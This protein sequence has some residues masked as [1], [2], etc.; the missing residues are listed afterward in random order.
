MTRSNIAKRLAR[1][2][3]KSAKTVEKIYICWCGD[4]EHSPDC[5]VSLADGDRLIITWEDD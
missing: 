5:Q 3:A 1:I 4:G 2:E